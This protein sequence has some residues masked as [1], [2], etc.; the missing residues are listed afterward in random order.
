LKGRRALKDVGRVLEL[1]GADIEEVA[2][3]IPGKHDTIEN[4]MEYEPLL[5]KVAEGNPE[6]GEL[7]FR[8]AAL[9]GVVMSVGRNVAAVAISDRPVSEKVPVFDTKDGLVT[10]FSMGGVEKVGVVTHHLLGSRVLTVIREAVRRIQ[11]STGTQV[12]VENI[13]L[14]DASTF[15]MLRRR[16]VSGVFQCDSGGFVDLI[17]KLQPER[18]SHLVDAIALYRP[19]PI[20]NGAKDE[21]LDRRNGRPGRIRVVIPAIEEIIGDTYGIIL[22]QEQIMDLA[23]RLAGF[24]M[25]EAD[26]FRVAVCRGNSGRERTPFIEGGIRNG[27]PKRR[28]ERIFGQ[29]ENEGN[30]SFCKA[31]AV[32]YGMILYRTAFLKCHWPWEY[33]EA[34]DKFDSRNGT[35]G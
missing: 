6:L 13:P 26:L 34:V 22:Y 29:I 1:H 32:G 28:M 33:S 27:H 17:G 31:H 19:Q 24:S 11:E 10:Q 16:D 3:M 5:R 21:Y 25:E 2:G 4:G 15:L 14:N 12:D 23:A 18:F 7:V 9:E 30:Y 8:A 35:S 20:R